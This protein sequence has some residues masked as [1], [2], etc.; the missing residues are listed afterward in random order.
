MTCA[1]VFLVGLWLVV[2]P[3]PARVCPDRWAVPRKWHA[4]TGRDLWSPQGF[5][6][7]A[8]GTV[9]LGPCR[10]AGHGFVR[11]PPDFTFHLDG[12]GRY[13]R[14]HLRA[15]A[16]CDTVLLLRAPGGGWSFD[17]DSGTG[18]TALLSLADP[19]D[20]AYLVW[21]GSFGTQGCVARLTI[22]TF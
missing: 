19:V 17:D 7:E 10:G 5:A 11:G 20:G 21:V 15:N 2:W 18:S 14:L 3:G 12:M 8:G 16:A 22:D 9:A 1:G 6:V 4:M 13:A